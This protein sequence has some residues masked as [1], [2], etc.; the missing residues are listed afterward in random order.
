M[1]LPQ[2]HLAY[3]DCIAAFDAALDNPVGVRVQMADQDAC[4]RFRMRC[5]QVRVLQRQFNAKAFDK[6]HVM[7]NASAWDPIIVRIKED[8]GRWYVYFEK[9]SVGMGAIEP[10]AEGTTLIEEEPQKALPPPDEDDFANSTMVVE[11]AV[12]HIPLRRRV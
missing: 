1:S 10:L 11:D 6:G 8:D 12:E 7:H 4:I 5:N 2:S 3:P 9:V